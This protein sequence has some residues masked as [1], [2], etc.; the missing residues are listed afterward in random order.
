MTRRLVVTGADGFV[1][2]NLMLRLAELDRF[3]GVPLVRASDAGEWRDAVASA[4]AVIHLAGVNRPSDPAAFAGNADAAA[5]LADAVTA[6]DRP[7]PILYASSAKAI[8]D[9]PYGRSKKSGEDRLLALAEQTGAPV[10]IYRLP[11]VF[12]KWCRPDYNS[13]VATFCHNIARDLPIRIDDP[14]TPLTLVYVDDVIDAWIAAI[15]GGFVTGF[16]DIAPVYRSSVGAV[17]ET[18]RGFRDGRADNLIDDVGTGLTRALYATYVS[19]LPPA[20]FSYP[21]VSHR[22]PRGAFS[23]M[24]KTRSAGQFSYFTALPGITR[25]GHYHHTKTEKFLIVHGQAL[26]RFRHMLT[27]ETHEIRTSGDTPEIVETIPGWAHDVTNVG[28]SDMVSLLWAN[29][30]FD[31]A[32]P[33]TVVA[34]L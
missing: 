3:S 16:H 25:G 4:D 14:A 31:R 28:D 18:L 9:T 22:D 5:L 13:A 29:E 21:I 12:G 24:L 20:D 6:A 26:F 17:A 27:G 11:N 23:E 32:R 15:D 2:R 8:D 10:A 7:V 33:D 19:Y 30:V 1:G 34:P